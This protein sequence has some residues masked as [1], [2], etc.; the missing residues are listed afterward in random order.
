MSFISTQLLPKYRVTLPKVL[1]EL[2]PTTYLG[3]PPLPIG[4][5]P[6]TL[7]GEPKRYDTTT[8]SGLST[9]SV[10]V[11]QKSTGSKVRG[12]G[13]QRR[14]KRSG[15]SKNNKGNG[16]NSTTKRSS[17]TSKRRGT[18]NNGKTKASRGNSSSTSTSKVRVLRLKGG[19]KA[20]MQNG[21]FIKKPR[22]K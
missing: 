1:Q 6:V 18:G 13:G 16:N 2:V 21:K 14:S 7:G 9:G 11:S 5:A 8:I 22:G 3:M 15:N 12:I 4:T 19:R 10:N 17:A 20:Y